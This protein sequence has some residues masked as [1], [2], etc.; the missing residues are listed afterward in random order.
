M[1]EAGVFYKKRGKLMY[2]LRVQHAF[3]WVPLVKVTKAIGVEV[4][5][6]ILRQER[7]NHKKRLQWTSDAV[8][9]LT[10]EERRVTGTTGRMPR[11]EVRRT[12]VGKN[13]ELSEDCARAQE[14]AVEAE[15]E[16]ANN[17]EGNQ[18]VPASASGLIEPKLEEE[19]AES[20][21]EVV[22]DG[23]DEECEIENEELKMEP[24]NKWK[25]KA[26]LEA[27]PRVPLKRSRTGKRW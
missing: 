25:K 15:A 6:E 18:P 1:A 3:E 16:E 20:D 23:D 12:T 26:D 10:P 7:Q 9:A 8:R 5:Q 14:E 24:L 21:I 27:D 2:M 11:E 13:C 22:A 17:E 4:Y 19:R